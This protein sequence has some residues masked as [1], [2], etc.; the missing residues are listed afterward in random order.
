M[1]AQQHTVDPT[2]RAEHDTM[3]IIKRMAPVVPQPFGWPIDATPIVQE[4]EELARA[5]QPGLPITTA[6]AIGSA[7]A[8][9]EHESQSAALIVVGSRARK[10]LVGVALGSVGMHLDAQARCPL[11]VVHHAERW[12][13]PETPLPIHEP[14]VTGIDG[15]P[16][17]Q[18]ALELAFEEATIRDLPLRVF[19]TGTGD[20]VTAVRR[21]FPDVAVTTSVCHEGLQPALTDAS[22]T[23]A[24]LVVGAHHG[25][26][27]RLHIDQQLVY[28]AF[29]PVLIAHD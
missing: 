6:L 21:R 28:H 20:D 24:L 25:F 19:R 7:G 8:A 5:W 26:A 23:A 18:L 22:R 16:A 10:P 4:A 13:G 29:C 12:A 11:L 3:L 17:A 27:A 15:T 2:V 9:L 1:S 14:V